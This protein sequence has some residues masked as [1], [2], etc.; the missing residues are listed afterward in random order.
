[1][2]CERRK[3]RREKE[4]TKEDKVRGTGIECKKERKNEEK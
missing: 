4:E 3:V 2:G 1:M